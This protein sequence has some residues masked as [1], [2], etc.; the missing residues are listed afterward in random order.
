[1]AFKMKSSVEEKLAPQMYSPIRRMI[2]PRTSRQ[3]RLTS[4]QLGSEASDID[5]FEELYGIVPEGFYGETEMGDVVSYAA[6]GESDEWE[7]EDGRTAYSERVLVLNNRDAQLMM[8][9]LNYYQSSGYEG[10]MD[11]QKGLAEYSPLYAPHGDGW[12]VIQ[13]TYIQDEDGRVREIIVEGYADTYVYMYDEEGNLVDK[14]E[15]HRDPASRE[16]SKKA[17][18]LRPTT[19]EIQGAILDTGISYDNYY[20]TH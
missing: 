4:S 18:R 15:E 14:K 16:A 8:D 19:Y 10:D 7:L 6:W 11:L 13:T 3:E 12:S 20:D 2:D 1:M 5:N 9:N 17:S